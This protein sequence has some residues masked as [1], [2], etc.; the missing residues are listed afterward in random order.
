MISKRVSS[1]KYT[2]LR[3]NSVRKN[4]V[5]VYD[6]GENDIH[7]VTVEEEC[8]YFLN[9]PWWISNSDSG[10]WWGSDDTL[11]PGNRTSAKDNLQRCGRG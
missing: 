1:I 11:Q 2:S 8:V 5:E 9:V 7:F 6:R 3:Y 4:G 10:A